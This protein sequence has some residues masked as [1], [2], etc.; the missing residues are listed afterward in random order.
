MKIINI[1]TTTSTND[2]LKALL[3]L[4]NLENFTVVQAM[5]QTKGRGQLGNIWQSECDKNLIFSILLKHDNFSVT[6]QFDINKVVALAVI[7][8][9]KKYFDP[10]TIK[11]PNDIMADNK[12]IGGILIENIIRGNTNNYSVVGI[13]ININ[14]ISFDDLLSKAISLQQLTHKEYDLL[15]LT[16]VLQNAVIEQTKKIN[17]VSLH[18]DYWNNLWGKDT[19]MIF[20]LPDDTKFTGKIHQISPQGLLIVQS[21]DGII[22]TFDLKQVQ[23]GYV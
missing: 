9:L 16:Q 12:K 23:F 10:V 7:K 19:L 17:D 22:H 3:Q 14:Q 15:V 18:Q 21:A 1:H 11:W 13:G 4:E 2:Y 8:F 20:R 5:Y 6:R